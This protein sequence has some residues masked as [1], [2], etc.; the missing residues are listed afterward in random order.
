MQQDY[1]DDLIRRYKENKLTTKEHEILSAWLESIDYN[2]KDFVWDKKNKTYL[3]NRIH[4]EL[5]LNKK[6]FPLWPKIAAAA[7]AIVFCV[8]GLSLYY[9]HKFQEQAPHIEGIV[10]SEPIVPGENKGTLY[11]EEGVKVQ[12]HTLK[13]DTIYKLDKL[14]VKRIA[15]NEIQILP[16]KQDGES[17]QYIEAP[18]GGN[19]VVQLED[20][21]RLTL[22]ANSRI[23]FPTSFSEDNRTVE[24]AG[25]ILFEV[26]KDSRQRPF[27]VKAGK[28]TIQVLGT[29]F[30][31]KHKEG[32]S[33]RA[34]LFEGKIVVTSPTFRVNLDPGN[35]IEVD[36]KGNYK[37]KPF[38]TTAVSAWT[39]GY[40]SLDNKNIVEIMEELG[41]WYDV[42]VIYNEADLNIKYQGSISKF[43][44]IKTVLEILTLAKGNTFEL[45]GRRIMVK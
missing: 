19:F 10:S 24:T 16:Q 13:L 42:E 41:N 15:E 29:T 3:K 23:T 33:L 32:T 25:E 31:I 45:E 21:S 39:D 40:F 4:K 17:L 28:N 37:V 27:I 9:Q 18:K 11:N 36:N 8:A 2:S 26:K 44:D 43:T 38:T 12:L 22:N 1:F 30:N 20:G 35:E 6:T 34:S 7:I 5:E 14:L